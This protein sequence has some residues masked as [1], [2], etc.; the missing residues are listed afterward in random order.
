MRDD[1]IRSEIHRWHKWNKLC[2]KVVIVC[3]MLSSHNGWQA[4]REPR[5]GGGLH[6]AAVML[7]LALGGQKVKATSKQSNQP[8]PPRWGYLDLM[9]CYASLRLSLQ[10][11]FWSL[12]VGV[13]PGQTPNNE[14]ATW[15]PFFIASPTTPAPLAFWTKPLDPSAD[16]KD[17]SGDRH[18]RERHEGVQKHVRARQDICEG[19][20]QR[21]ERYATEGLRVH[22]DAVPRVRLT[23][24]DSSD[25]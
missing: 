4:W 13:Q 25:C 14:S 12:L 10:N 21:R 2:H 5:Q 3:H 1:S 18:G 6:G 16:K 17:P 8:A 15:S 19:K 7:L 11:H 20:K 22:G 9:L 24:S 23:S